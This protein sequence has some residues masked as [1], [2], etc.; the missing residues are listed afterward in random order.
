MTRKELRDTR[1]AV[2]GASL[3][4]EP[5]LEGN[6]RWSKP[7]HCNRLINRQT[8]RLVAIITL[9]YAP[10]SIF[11]KDP[12]AKSR[13]FEL[14]KHEKDIGYG[15]TEETRPYQQI[16]DIDKL[17]EERNKNTLYHYGYGKE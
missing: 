15:L 16:N 12:P 7:A 10:L 8:L 13:E 17:E 3:I 9:L 1:R 2:E 5:R 4:L 14:Q 6:L 11:L